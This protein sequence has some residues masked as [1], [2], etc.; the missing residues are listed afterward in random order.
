MDGNIMMINW[1]GNFQFR[2]L[3]IIIFVAPFF[4]LGCSGGSSSDSGEGIESSLENPN[5]NSN[6]DDQEE[7]DDTNKDKFTYSRE[8]DYPNI[9]K[10]PL[11]FFSTVNGKKIGVSVTLPANEEGEPIDDVF[12]AL[13]V[14]TAY[15]MSLVSTPSSSGALTGGADPFFVKRGYAMVTVDVLGSGVS[16]GG[17]ELL[18]EE[19]QN[20]YGDAVDWVLRQDWSDGN[21]GVSGASYMAIAALFTAQQ[22]PDAVKAVFAV[23]PLGDAQR[24]TAGTGGLLNGIFMKTW[25]T[26]TQKLG[27]QN[28]LSSL[29]NPQHFSQIL[30]STQEHI[31]HIDSFYLPLIDDALAGEDYIRYDGEFWRTR[32]PLED[33]DKIT[34]PTFITGALHD[35]FQ[36]DEPLLYE[37][38]QG[39]VDARLAIFDGDHM[40]NMLQASEGNDAISPLAELMLQWFDKHIKGLDSG[41]EH[42]AAVTQYVKNYESESEDGFAT[43][44]AWPHPLAEP[45]RWYLHGDLSL[46]QELPLFDEGNLTMHASDFAKIE[47]GKSS[48]GQF[49]VFNVTP[50]DGSDC[51]ISYRQ[52]TLGGAATLNANPC[53]YDNSE[54]E[55]DALNYESAPMSDDYYINGPIQ[56]DIWIDSTVTEAVVSVRVDEVSPDGSVVLPLTNGL[57][58][59]TSR[60]V[61]ESRSRY[62]NGEMIQPF[63]YLTAEHAAEVVPGEVLKMQIEIFPTS[64]IIRQGH[65]LRISISPSN[66]AQGVMNIPQQDNSVGGITTIHNSL[67]YP[68]SIVLPIVPLSALN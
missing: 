18:S 48:G 23:V 45:N 1:I 50:V 56:A 51:S 15:N 28:V 19:E 40:S 39:N 3:Y 12:P 52:W 49:L 61:D 20:G 27:T 25:M 47:Y 55:V 33:I 65:R 53:Y 24:G 26:L 13:L 8:E 31:G 60:S 62:L 63:H 10:L 46:S 64:A 22:R 6:D 5:N 54:V 57:L 38:L 32:A 67:E 17:W 42:I 58:A 36:R 21:I 7:V 30:R 29:L 9:V 16:E 43:T 34:A 4:L 2:F 68:S 14:Q 37:Q 35:I 59:A 11:E 66:Q 41:T 44:T